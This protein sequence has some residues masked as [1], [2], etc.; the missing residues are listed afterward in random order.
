MTQGEV[1]APRRRFGRSRDKAASKR[2]RVLGVDAQEVVHW[3]FR[4]LLTSEPWVERYLAAETADQALDLARRYEPNVALLDHGF[5][6]ELCRDIRRESPSTAVLLMSEEGMISARA[7]RS[8]GAYGA[9]PKDWS[10]HDIVGAVRMVGLGMT[11]FPP[12]AQPI[13][14]LSAR[15]F[16][17]LELIA[18]GATNREI[19]AALYISPHTVKDHTSSVYRK[20]HARN[21]AEATQVAQRL[22]LLV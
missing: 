4:T 22:G 9:I 5:G 8:V 2:L 10:I 1:S 15:E 3:G 12:D 13:G 20:M 21:R 7:A 6:G 19:A 17:V 11:L 18:K 14:L 16:Q